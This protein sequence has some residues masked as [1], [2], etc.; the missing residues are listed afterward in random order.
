MEAG[1]I[2]QGGWSFQSFLAYFLFG[3]VRFRIRRSN[4]MSGTQE[5]TP[6]S[7][8]IISKFSIRSESG[9]LT[10]FFSV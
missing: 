6:S 1:K 5:K 8:G 10:S 4:L 7:L 2:G 9:C 3:D